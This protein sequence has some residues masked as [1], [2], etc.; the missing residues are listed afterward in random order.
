MVDSPYQQAVDYLYSFI[1][2]ETIHQP[3]DAVSY[4]LRRMEELL[5]RLGSP[6]LKATSVHI[7]GTKG[8]GS[9]AAMVASVLTASGYKTGLYTSPH[10][11]DIRER[12]RVDG[13]LVSEA[14]LAEMVAKLK[15]EVSAYHRRASYGRLTTFELLTALGFLYF[16]QKGVELQVVEVGLGGR[17]DATN[18]I[19]PEVCVITSISLDHTDVLGNSLAEIATEKAGIIKP[20]A[21]V[22]SSPQADEV[23]RIIE[24]VCCGRKARLVMVGRDVTY[25]GLGFDDGSQLLRVNGLSASYK[26]SI[27]LLGHYQLKN[28]ATAVAAVEVL[29]LKGFNVTRESI[30][31]GLGQV[32]WPGRFQILGHSPLIVVDGAHNPASAAELRLSLDYYLKEKPSGRA[33]LVI[34]ASSDKDIAGIA[35][36]LSPPFDTVIATRSRHP[37]AMPPASITTAFK[38]AG[39]EVRTTSTIP[40]AL[41]LARQLAGEEGFICVAGSLFVVGEAMEQ[42]VQRQT[43]SSDS[44]A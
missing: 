6:H 17:L 43:D 28:A 2:Y 24:E 23:A 21:A 11:I 33:V 3:R 12:F 16:A 31:A 30:T 34:G 44:T 36:E 14:E 27:P 20:G 32:N 10:L 22:A 29:G 40:E 26:L 37:R 9:T 13:E 1:D 4:D 42:L 7:A 18:V 35:R 8:K 25:Q 38:N 19:K 5:A 39:L 15:P 41:E